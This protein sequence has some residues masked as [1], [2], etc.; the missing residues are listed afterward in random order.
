MYFSKNIRYLRKSRT[1]SQEEL[2][3]ILGYKSFTTIQKWESGVAEPPFSMVNKIADIFQV[4]VNQ[5][6]YEDIENLQTHAAETDVLI[7]PKEKEFRELL[8]ELKP[9]DVDNL[10]EMGRLLLYAEKYKKLEKGDR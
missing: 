8:I 7:V 4:S 6:V 2:A 9:E 3:N 1:M 5:L 10:Y